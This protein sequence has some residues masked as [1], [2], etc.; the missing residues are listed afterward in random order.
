MPQRELR[1]V[2]L[3]DALDELDRVRAKY[4]SV[5]ALARVWIE[6]D[7]VKEKHKRSTAKKR[8]KSAA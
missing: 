2:A 7:A 6:V 4:R 8:R 3:A 1:E 5:V